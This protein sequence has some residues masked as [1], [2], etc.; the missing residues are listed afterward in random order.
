MDQ[1]TTAQLPTVELKRPIGVFLLS[2][3]VLYQSSLR[4]QADV[5]RKNLLA[6][7]AGKRWV[8]SIPQVATFTSSVV[9]NLLLRAV[10][11]TDLQD[12]VDRE[13]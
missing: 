7:N 9:V 10:E 11:I 5:E 3:F 1:V 12:C 8:R 13:F 4:V 6:I 2:F